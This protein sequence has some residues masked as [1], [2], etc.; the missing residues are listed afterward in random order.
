M[1]Y[2]ISDL[3]KYKVINIQGNLQAGEQTRLI[4]ETV[5]DLTRQGNH[6]FVFNLSD[7]TELDSTGISIFIHCL[8]DVQESNGSV[9]LVVNDPKVKEVIELV[10]LSR[11]IK[12][13]PSMEAFGKSHV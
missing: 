13:Y 11:L 10:G 7:L 5:T 8:C 9:Y 12:L 2:N 1:S 6:H 3:A 4:I